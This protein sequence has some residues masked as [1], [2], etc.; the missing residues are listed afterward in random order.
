VTGSLLAAGMIMAC[1]PATQSWRVPPA[2]VLGLW[3][4]PAFSSE[5]QCHGRQASETLQRYLPRARLALWLPG[6]RGVALDPNRGCITITVGTV[7]EGRLA[8]LVLRG[9]AVPRRSVLLIL[10]SSAGRS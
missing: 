9:V 6:T 10:A 8:E 7:G 3:P 1:G 2:P 4:D 5:R